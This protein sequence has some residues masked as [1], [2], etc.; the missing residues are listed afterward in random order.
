MQVT[1][2][3]PY[4]GNDLGI[5]RDENHLLFRW[6]ELDCLVIFSVT[7]KGNAISCHFASDSRGLRKLKKAISEWIEFCTLSLE[8]CK[9]ILANIKKPSVERLVKKLGFEQIAQIEDSRVWA[10]Y[11][12]RA[13]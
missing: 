6:L 9:I 7:R 5:A 1:R 3:I 4:Y 13:A 2:F 11:L 10:R 8:W 12:E